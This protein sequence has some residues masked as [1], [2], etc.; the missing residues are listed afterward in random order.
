ML[1]AISVFYSAAATAHQVD[2]HISIDEGNPLL[3]DVIMEIPEHTRPV[4][5][6]SRAASLQTQ[7]QVRDVACNDEELLINGNNEW[8]VPPSCTQIYWSVEIATEGDQGIAAYDQKTIMSKT[9]QWW[10]FSTTTGLLRLKD[11]PDELV[12]HISVPYQDELIIRIPSWRLAP[13]FYPLGN[14]PKSEFTF[15]NIS[16]NYISDNPELAARFVKPEDHAKA[17][18]Y[19]STIMGANQF[20]KKDFTM[21]LLGITRQNQSLGGAA[22]NQNMMVNYIFDAKGANS[23]EAYYPIII[24]LHEQIHQLRRGPHITWVSESLAQ[25]YASKATL[26]IYPEIQAVKEIVEELYASSPQN[27]PG[28]LEIQSRI[29]RLGDY[30][31]YDNFYNQGSAFWNELDVIIQKSTN[32]AESLDDYM[33]L[34]ME[35]EFKSGQGFPLRLQ[36]VFSFLPEGSLKNLEDKYLF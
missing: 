19:L 28:L 6:Y 7:T 25:F 35:T 11:E 2:Y 17:L 29:D 10:I 12:A 30:S 1:A 22:G 20:D 26:K 15:G 27:E 36:R 16:L 3:A 18:E 24:A 14:V 34:I 32:G 33:L 4:L 31:K 13:D 8:I 23:K 21:I 5:L 9:G